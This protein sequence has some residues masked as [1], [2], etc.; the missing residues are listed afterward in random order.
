MNR[1]LRIFG[2]VLMA[3]C[4]A[5]QQVPEPPVPIW[6]Q[7]GKIPPELQDRYVFITSGRDALMILLPETPG[8]DIKGPKKVV[9]YPLYNQLDP[10]VAFA[11]RELQPSE[12]S[13]TYSSMS[14]PSYGVPPLRF[15]SMVQLEA[16]GDYLYQY[17][18]SNG[19]A[20]KDAIGNW[21]L[22]VA[23]DTVAVPTHHT[24]ED[25]HASWLSGWIATPGRAGGPWQQA[26]VPG[27]PNGELVSWFLS[28]ASTTG[29]RVAPGESLGGF[30]IKSD[31]KPG[32]TTAY[33]KVAPADDRSPL[34]PEE[35]P[36]EVAAQARF[37]TNIRLDR[38]TGLTLGP[39]FTLDAPRAEIVANFR[40]GIGRWIE[41]HQ[42]DPQSSFVKE[43]QQALQT[44][45]ATG[46]DGVIQSQPTNQRETE[47]MQALRISLG[48]QFASAETP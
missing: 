31:R 45:P 37:L 23:A 15:P 48:F 40:A 18:I 29:V 42:L 8:G 34:D 3:G 7:D 17:T 11:I 26:E 39:M 41:K 24:G 1:Q 9:R 16:E 22:V 30:Q 4:L 27:A 33:F 14:G 44:E 21:S 13:L 12:R 35:I 25:V 5:A 19:R 20:A 10:G 43:V 28:A 47:I 36:R 6:P 38:K 32:F 2:F 46:Q